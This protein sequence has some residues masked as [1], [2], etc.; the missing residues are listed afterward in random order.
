M[1]VPESLCFWQLDS[2]KEHSL[3]FGGYLG[4]GNS[5]SFPRISQIQTSVGTPARG[6]DIE[7]HMRTHNASYVNLSRIK[8]TTH[9]H[10][11]HTHTHTSPQENIFIGKFL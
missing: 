9:T 8:E 5:R 7:I 3:S 6:T 2:S 11:T 10:T 4:D 1:E